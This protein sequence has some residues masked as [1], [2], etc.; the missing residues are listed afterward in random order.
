MQYFVSFSAYTGI[1]AG[2]QSKK[3]GNDQELTKYLLINDCSSFWFICV[4]ELVYSLQTMLSLA[5]STSW[6]PKNG[7]K[8]ACVSAETVQCLPSQNP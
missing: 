5:Q 2:I 1:I 6:G 7:P 8:V 3:K 4:C